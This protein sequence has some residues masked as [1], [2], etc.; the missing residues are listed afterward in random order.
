MDSSVLTEG[1][2]NVEVTVTGV[3]TAGNTAVAVQHTTVVL[4]TQAANAISIDTVAG[5]NVVNRSESRMPTLISGAV[6]GDAQPGDNVAVAVN[7]RTFTGL[8]VTD[9]HGALPLGTQ[10]F[11]MFFYSED[12]NDWP[13]KIFLSL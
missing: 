12:E 5:D 10:D 9:E 13:H 7:G 8:V 6:T 3:D 2:N 1:S 4:D 11:G